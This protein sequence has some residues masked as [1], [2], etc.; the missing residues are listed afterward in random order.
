MAC[1]GEFI[2]FIVSRNIRVSPDFV[3]GEGGGSLLQ[4]LDHVTE[5]SHIV[6]ALNIL[7]FK[8]LSNT[9]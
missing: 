4:H 7:D 9:P 3:Y 2:S 6:P 8:P 5:H 1:F